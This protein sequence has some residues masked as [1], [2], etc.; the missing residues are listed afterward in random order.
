MDEVW[1]PIQGTLW[2][3]VSNIGRVRRRAHKETDC[4]GR[5]K[6]YGDLILSINTDRLGYKIVQIKE[7]K[8]LHKDTYVHRMVARAFVDNPDGKPCVN[9]IDNNPSNNVYTNLEW[10]THKEN[11]DWMK[12]QGRADRTEEW[13]K[14]LN[15]GLDFLRKRVVG[16]NIKTGEKIYFDGVNKTADAGFQ[17]SCVSN[18]CNGKRKTHGGYIWEFAWEQ[19]QKAS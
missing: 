9:H 8:C 16:T 10:C 17:P 15:I 14:N 3:D 19:K 11:M 6:T 7:N 12:V 1:R 13:I 4:Y 18:C 2:H 5:S